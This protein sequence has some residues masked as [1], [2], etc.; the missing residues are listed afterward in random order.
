MAPRRSGFA[1]KTPRPCYP[2]FAHAF[3]A[4]LAAVRA[5]GALVALGCGQPEE[6]SDIGRYLS[7]FGVDDPGVVRHLPAAAGCQWFGVD[8]RRG[9]HDLAVPDATL[10][11]SVVVC[12]GLLERG[13]TEA[14][15]SALRHCARCS[16]VVVITC[17]EDALPPF[18]AGDEAEAEAWFADRLADHG[19]VAAFVGRTWGTPSRP[20]QRR[21]MLMAV[22]DAEAN[23]P[24]GAAPNEFRVQALVRTF[25]E[26]DIVVPV[27][28][29]LL[30]DG[31]EVVIIDNWSSD[32]TFELVT[33]RFA[34]TPRVTMERWPAEG[35][36]PSFDTKASLQ[37]LEALAHRSGADWSI[38]NDADEFRQ[39]PWPAVGLRDALFGVH[40]RGYSAVDHTVVSFRPTDGEL[41][42][43]DDPTRELRHFEFVA[44][45]PV[46]LNAWRNGA[47]RVVLHRSGGHL[48]EFDG[49]RVF[50]YKFLLRHYPLRSPAHAQRKIFTERQ[51]RWNVEETA[52]GWHRH[53]DE[54]APGDG[55]IWDRDSLFEWD[56]RFFGR[57][58]LERL[59]GLGIVRST[60]P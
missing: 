39:S 15:W 10:A 27:V 47:Q 17:G 23:A 16:N 50:P 54:F 29:R 18:L 30:G 7:V 56:E 14:L 21:P 19:L 48:V 59:S 42:E 44:P 38:R 25:N 1:A 2:V 34:G 20:G 51:G 4:R 22:V 28:E 9:R 5:K 36:S 37:R 57:Y 26:R 52:K 53:Y 33:E 49:R 46:Q 35:P 6:L 31:V 60:R 32:G 41:G 13:P 55:F 3:A 43:G 40:A 12:A 11:E 45:E 58:L 8:L 24:V